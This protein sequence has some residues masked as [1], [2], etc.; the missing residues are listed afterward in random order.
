MITFSY[1]ELWSFKVVKLDVCHAA[2]FVKS[3][4]IAN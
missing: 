1:K 2:G 3:I 4:H